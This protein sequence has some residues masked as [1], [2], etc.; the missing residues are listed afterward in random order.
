MINKVKFCSIKPAF[1]GVTTAIVF[2]TSALFV[3]YL[4]VA[5]QSLLECS[6]KEN[7]Y[8]IIILSNE[9]EEYDKNLLGNL[10]IQQENISI[11]FCDPTEIVEKYIKNSKY[12]YLN[13]NYYRLALPWIL[14]N[15]DKALNLGADIIIEKDICEL[16]NTYMDKDKYIAGVIDLGYHGRLNMDIPREELNMADPYDYI[17]ADVILLNLEKIRNDFKQDDIMLFWQ[18]RKLRCAE[19]DAFNVLFDGHIQH[20][21]LNWN[22]FPERM[23]STEHILN[24]PESSVNLWKKAITT[25]YIIHYAAFPKPWDYPMI[26]YGYRWW[27]YA[28]KSPYYEEVVRR[29]CIIAARNERVGILH[30]VIDLLLPR[31]TTRRDVIKKL[32]SKSSKIRDLAYKIYH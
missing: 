32:L 13:L 19:Q 17:N 22:L 27:E 11:R 20:L 28:R 26:G 18:K 24:A 23:S 10:T 14:L 6:S 30:R 9:I 5:L 12:Q 8:D 1:S 3:P 7:F 16:I 29:M 25:P 15:Y 21:C 2:E 4:S 31:G